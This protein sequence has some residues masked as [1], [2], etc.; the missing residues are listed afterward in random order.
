MEST[1]VLVVVVAALVKLALL[2]T[3]ALVRRSRASSSRGV[4][5]DASPRHAAGGDAA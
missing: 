4:V 3:F 5:C 2:L 1:L